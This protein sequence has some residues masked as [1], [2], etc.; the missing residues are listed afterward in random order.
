ME[1]CG[2]AESKGAGYATTNSSIWQHQLTSVFC[3]A[4]AALL[5]M[6]YG[7]TIQQGALSRC[8]RLGWW[9]SK[10][11]RMG[12]ETEKKKPRGMID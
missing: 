9:A 7:F 12:L 11:M 10:Q 5:G 4:P 8:S 6:N 1:V 3:K 2:V